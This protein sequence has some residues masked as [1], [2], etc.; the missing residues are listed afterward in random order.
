M[1]RGI[2]IG[3]GIFWYGNYL[4]TLIYTIKG[5]WRKMFKTGVL[6]FSPYSSPSDQRF[7]SQ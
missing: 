3:I 5:I 1:M 2:A 4:V 6:S 7:A